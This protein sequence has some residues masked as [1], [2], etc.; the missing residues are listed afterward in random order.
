[1]NGKETKRTKGRRRE[2]FNRKEPRERK[3]VGARRGS[4]TA[5]GGDENAKG[6]RH[7]AAEPQP[8]R[9][10]PQRHRDTEPRKARRNGKRHNAMGERRQ[11]AKKICQ[12]TCRLAANGTSARTQAKRKPGRNAKGAEPDWPKRIDATSGGNADLRVKSLPK[13]HNFP[14]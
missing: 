9:I 6:I 12:I 13:L 1:M 14:R 4:G 8:K 3:G 2:P 7:S 5:D 10:S 11:D